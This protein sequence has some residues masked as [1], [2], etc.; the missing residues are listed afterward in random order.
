MFSVVKLDDTIKLVPNQFRNIN[1]QVKQNIINK[2]ERKIIGKIDG[3][4]IKIIDIDE[5]YIKDGTIYDINGSVNYI[6][7]YTSVIFTPVKD[8]ILDVTVKTCNEIG[9]FCSVDLIEENNQTKTK[10]NAYGQPEVI[11]DCLCPKDIIGPDSYKYD[12]QKNVWAN[13]DY[14]ITTSSKIIIKILNFQIEPNKIIII[15]TIV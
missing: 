4:V 5:N 1:E 14:I 7:K 11:I 15:G 8:G 3:Y 6:I 10:I 13:K 2:Y 9:L 12:S